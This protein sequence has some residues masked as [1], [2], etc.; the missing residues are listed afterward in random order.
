[1]SREEATMIEEGM[2]IAGC[3]QVAEDVFER[4]K[5]T[6]VKGLDFEKAKEL[7]V[8]NRISNL[9]C[10]MHSSIMAAYRIYG[11]ADH[12][13][14]ELG[15]RRNDIAREMNLFEKSVERFFQFW[16]GY[17]KGNQNAEVNDDIETLFHHIMRWAQLPETWK[18]G[19]EQRTKTTEGVAI[20]VEREGDSTLYFHRS[21]EY[22][23]QLEEPRESWCVVR[24]DEKTLKSN[25][26]NAGMDKPSAMMVAK[27]LSADDSDAIYTANIVTESVEKRTDILPIKAF[28]NNK[29]VG[30]L[31]NLV[32]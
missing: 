13:I 10:A 29:T 11:G 7:G 15:A 12:L 20:K 28:K 32:K 21:S 19:E 24:Y 6:G 17:Y 31:K 4:I 26:V 8:L 2:A 18:L 16:T 3:T 1:M 14:E 5:T 9:L 25:V 23:E 30:K 27:R 22:Y